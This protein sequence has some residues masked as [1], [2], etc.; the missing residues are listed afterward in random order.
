MKQDVNILLRGYY[1]LSHPTEMRLRTLNY[2]L[3]AEMILFPLE[4]SPQTES[5]VS[6]RLRL[7]NVQSSHNRSAERVSDETA[8][9]TTQI[10]FLQIHTYV[11]S[12]P[13]PAL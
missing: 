3:I 13:P 1:N 12:L 8:K 10:N 5:F 6:A 4:L 2:L 11:Q 7:V 9:N